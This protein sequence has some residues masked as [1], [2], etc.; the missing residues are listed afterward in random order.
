MENHSYEQII[1]SREAPY[2][3]ALTR[4]HG[5]ATG[6]YAIYHP[7]LP[8]YL[9]LVAGATMGC[10]DDDCRG[11]YDGP[12]LAGQLRKKG[13]TWAGFFE[14]LPA[15]G[16]TGDDT[17]EY[18]RHHDPFVYFKEVTASAFMRASIRPM[19]DLKPSLSNPPSFSLVV[20]DNRHNMHDGPISAADAWAATYVAMVLRSR[21]FRDH[22]AVFVTW[23]EGRR[24]DVS[25][26]CGPAI[27]GGHIATIVV[28]SG[29][30]RGFRSPVPHSTYS[31]LRTIENG[32][33]LPALRLAG[34]PAAV[35]LSEFW[36]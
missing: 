7:S 16:Y 6:F 1:G 32:F 3:N 2:L 26:C 20:P 18:I 8:N 11:G 15:R 12:T 23:D 19:A 21:A 25:G 5:L 33:G 24:S 29:A 14:G 17:G 28:G 9:A 13:L 4:S 35:P 22:G 34:G 27:H 36:P 31:L 10:T 30:R